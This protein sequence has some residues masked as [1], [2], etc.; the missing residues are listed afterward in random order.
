MPKPAQKPALTRAAPRPPLIRAAPQ[1]A[2]PRPP[3][4]RA[5]P[6]QEPLKQATSPFGQDPQPSPF[7]MPIIA[8]TAKPATQRARG[9]PRYA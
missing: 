2:A 8:A 7:G 4:L 5:A 9:A 1:K 3:A 6:T